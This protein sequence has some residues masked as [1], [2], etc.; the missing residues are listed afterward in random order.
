MFVVKH[1]WV[2]YHYKLC[3]CVCVW[4]GGRS[5]RREGRMRMGKQQFWGRGEKGK[6]GRGEKEGVREKGKGER[7]EGGYKRGDEEK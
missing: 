4:V 7:G 3:A 2:A 1:Q 6:R 5:E